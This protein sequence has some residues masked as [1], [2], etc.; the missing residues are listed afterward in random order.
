VGATRKRITKYAPITAYHYWASRSAAS[1]NGLNL[2]VIEVILDMEGNKKGC[3]GLVWCMPLAVALAVG[4]I[5]HE[6]C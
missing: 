6:S 5:M 1:R 4:E 2:G 3:T